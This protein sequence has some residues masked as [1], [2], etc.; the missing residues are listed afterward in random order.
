MRIEKATEVT[1]E[2]LDAF[3]RLVPQLT[4]NNPPPSLTD[5]TALVKSVSS[6]LLIARA[7]DLTIVGALSLTVYRTP[8]GIRSIIEDF[9][10][11]ERARGQGIGK[12]LLRRALEV[13]KQLG[14]KQVTLTSNPMRESANQ[15]Y[16]RLGFKRRETN[17]YIYKF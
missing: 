7:D 14:A 13:A 11:D 9:V 10:V 5:L 8:T 4:A 3:Q 16:S 6:T 12:A 2:L 17:S 15:L 1:D